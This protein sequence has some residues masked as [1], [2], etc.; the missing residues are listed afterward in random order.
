[1]SRESPRRLGGDVDTAGLA[2]FRIIDPPRVAPKPRLSEST[3]L[4]FCPLARSVQAL[5]ASFA[6]AQMFPTFHAV[7]AL[8]AFTQRPFWAA[9]RC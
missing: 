8:R 3:R 4:N 6:M 2:E 1:M 9:C 5:G 7:T